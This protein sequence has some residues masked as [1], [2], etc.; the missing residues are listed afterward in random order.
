MIIDQDYT[1]KRKNK[2]VNIN[3]CLIDDFFQFY[4]A[5]YFYKN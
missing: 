2:W 5:I 1:I 3:Q 4:N